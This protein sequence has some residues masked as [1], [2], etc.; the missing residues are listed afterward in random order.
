MNNG[1]V[2]NHCI[3][4]KQKV[5]TNSEK[6]LTKCTY[7]LSIAPIISHARHTSTLSFS[8]I[9]RYASAF[10]LCR[11]LC[12]ALISQHTAVLQFYQN[13]KKRKKKIGVCAERNGV[14]V[15][16]L[17]PRSHSLARV[18][19]IFVILLSP[20]FCIRNRTNCSVLRFK[21]EENLFCLFLIFGIKVFVRKN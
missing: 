13:E 7:H 20:I 10:S 12:S 5:G 4:V 3:V 17:S 18:P 8:P 9:Q 11:I 1:E 16:E 14:F 15:W 19:N 21:F 6:S 2:R